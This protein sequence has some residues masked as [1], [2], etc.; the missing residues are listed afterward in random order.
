M[1]LAA[2][3]ST[4]SVDGGPGAGGGRVGWWRRLTRPIGEPRASS[5]PSHKRWR[6]SASKPRSSS[7][8]R[9]APPSAA[10]PRIL[11]SAL[12]IYTG[13]PAAPLIRG[14]GVPAA[15]MP[16]DPQKI[17]KAIIDTGD[18]G[19]CQLR[20]LLGSDAFS[21]VHAVLTERLRPSRT[22]AR[23][24]WQPTQ[25]TT[26]R[27]RSRHPEEIHLD[28]RDTEPGPALT[29]S[30][31][32]PSGGSPAS[33]VE[34]ALGPPHPFGGDLVPSRLEEQQPH[35]TTEP[36]LGHCRTQAPTTMRCL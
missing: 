19:T 29:S 6:P 7:P 31:V 35:S 10:L 21:M 18:P 36:F 32:S 15:A 27:Q 28:Y 1:E 5:S 23:S 22:I 14:D 16:G 3:I 20:L 13:T 34:R 30:A 12:D 4:R 33:A 25:T 24:A 8:E 9:G 26:S 2:G 17:A 11:V